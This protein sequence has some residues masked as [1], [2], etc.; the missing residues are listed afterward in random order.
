M[1]KVFLISLIASF[2]AVQIFLTIP[3][4]AAGFY[5]I[6]NSTSGI[7]VQATII[8]PTKTKELNVA[9]QVFGKRTRTYDPPDYWSWKVTGLAD[10]QE[11][12]KMKNGGGNIEVNCTRDSTNE[13]KYWMRITIDK[14]GS[15]TYFFRN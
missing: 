2:I 13:N 15:C 1:K 3:V 12:E 5:V 4:Q 14:N 8:N 11:Y 7:I 9:F 6:N 10:V